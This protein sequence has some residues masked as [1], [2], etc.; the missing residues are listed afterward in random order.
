MKLKTW[1]L[2]LFTAISL[3]VGALGQTP[4]T[5]A[6]SA[7]SKT[8]AA[9][10]AAAD[11]KMADAAKLVDL[12]AASADDLKALPGIGDKYSQKI[13]DGRPYANKSQLLSKN[14]VPAATYK[15]IEKMVI[16]KQK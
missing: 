4:A 2:T 10:S 3:S 15:K 5:A 12:N 14:I 6:K 11:K 16:A 8:T 1:V 13:I 9:T 7:A